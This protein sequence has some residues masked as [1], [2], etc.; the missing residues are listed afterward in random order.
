MTWEI[1]DSDYEQAKITVLGI[2]GGG[3]NSVS[4]MIN[5]GIKGV[6]F[7]C[8]NTDAQDLS[9]IHTAR[10]IVLGQELTKG[11]GAGNNPERGRAATEQSIEEIKE[12]LINTEM[13]FLVAGMGGG[14]GTG[15]AP[16][17]AKLAKDMGILT[18]GVVTTPFKHEGAKR[19]SQAK[20]GIKYLMESVDSLIEI[21]NEKIFQVFPE[22]T[23][24]SEGF[25]A[26]DDVL[27][28]ALKSVTN[29]I[30][31]DTARMNIDFA[32]VKAAMSHKGM[33]IM[34]YGTA[35]GTNRAAE[36]VHKALSNPFFDQA[37]MKNAK[38]LIVNVC[39]S[40]LEKKELPEIMNQVQNIGM[41]G[42]E[43]IPGL[44]LDTSYGDEL[45]VTIIATGLRRFDLD[46]FKTTYITSPTIKPLNESSGTNSDGYVNLNNLRKID[47]KETLRRLKD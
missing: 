33:A 20:L 4:H 37:E 45:S 28:N 42:I 17:I 47:I 30:L 2:G 34:C 35:T 13:L 38:G 8:A 43:A 23:D 32:D 6:N 31:T 36:A 1:L 44:M 12:L 18:V 15:G 7:I 29:V 22:D 26:V 27:T 21:D 10:K 46:N 14:T 39:A 11:L 3:G 24:L 41:E 5:S 40:A 25:D 9:K 16:I 19:A